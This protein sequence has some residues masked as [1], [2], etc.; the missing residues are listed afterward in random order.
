MSKRD[1]LWLVDEAT[2][3]DF[4]DLITVREASRQVNDDGLEQQP[5]FRCLLERPEALLR[6][7][8]VTRSRRRRAFPR[9]A[10]A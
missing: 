7:A 10:A 3:A 4:H 9:R 6:E 8:D 2:A 1:L 5:G